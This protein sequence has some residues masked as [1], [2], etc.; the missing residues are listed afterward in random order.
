MNG[1]TTTEHL[2]PTPCSFFVARAFGRRI[3]A[4]EK[5]SLIRRGRVIASGYRKVWPHGRQ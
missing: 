4:L 2:M 5:R 3:P 1:K